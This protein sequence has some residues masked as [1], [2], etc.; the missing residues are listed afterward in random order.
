MW[1][2]TAESYKGFKQ[3]LDWTD[4]IQENEL[5]EKKLCADLAISVICTMNYTAKP[6]FPEC[7]RFGTDVAQ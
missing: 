2:F 7:Q 6:Q 5:F 3:N 1:I 4:L